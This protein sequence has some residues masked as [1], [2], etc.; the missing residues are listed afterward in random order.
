[1]EQVSWDDIQIFQ[2]LN[3]QQTAN[4]PTGWEY[5]LL[6]ESQWNTPAVRGQVRCIRGGMI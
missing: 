3:D 2:G 1:M 6:T 5:V 4:I